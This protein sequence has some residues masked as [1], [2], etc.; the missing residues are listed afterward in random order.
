V[1]R[2]R[3]MPVWQVAVGEIVYGEG[4]EIVVTS[5]VS[6]VESCFFLF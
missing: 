2:D 6:V 3:A 1:E 5:T 4:V